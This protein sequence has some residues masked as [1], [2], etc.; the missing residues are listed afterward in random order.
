MKVNTA[1][2]TRACSFYSTVHG[3]VHCTNY[4]MFARVSIYMKVFIKEW[5]DVQCAVHFM[6][7]YTFRNVYT[8]H[9]MQM[10]S[11]HKEKVHYTVQYMKVFSVHCTVQ[12][13]MVYT[14]QLST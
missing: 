14:V 8:V 11:V 5:G 10:F 13:N 6:I 12:Y 1:A 2:S 3:V 7:V 9:I 4:E